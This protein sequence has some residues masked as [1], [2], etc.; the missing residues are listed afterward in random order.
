MICLLLIVLSSSYLTLGVAVSE[1]AQ[2]VWPF[3]A[4]AVIVLAIVNLWRTRRERP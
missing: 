3:Y 2:E 4:L 1:I